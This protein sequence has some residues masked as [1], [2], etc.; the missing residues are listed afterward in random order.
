[1]K[2]LEIRPKFMAYCLGGMPRM[3][4]E[5]A[6]KMM[7]SYFPEAITIPQ[8]TMSQRIWTERVP[9]MKIDRGKKELLFDLSSGRDAE[10]VEFYERY[11]SNDLEYFSISPEI[12][13]LYKL[14]ELWSRE[15]WPEL[16]V[17]HF[18]FPG[19]YSWGLSIK[20]D[21]GTPALYNE[22][23]RDVMIKSMYMKVK[24]REMKARELFPGAETM[25]TLGNGALSVY[26]SA[27]GTG[28]WEDVKRDYIEMVKDASG[29]IG[30]HCC[31]NFD[32]SLLME[33]GVDVL[34]FDAYQYGET[35]C[36]YGEA[37]GRFLEQGGMIAWGIVPTKGVGDIASE[38]PSRLIERLEKIIQRLVDEGT[39]K[40]RLLESSWVTPTC[41]VNTLSIEESKQVYEFTKEISERMREKYFG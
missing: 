10:L 25:V 33:M 4:V 31:S 9:L 17:I 23:L 40:E 39:N 8:P 6:C 18:N 36:L 32:W 14:A 20:D 5:E 29:I 19:L 16:K 27:G 7:I 11:A 41:E 26:F 37:L 28:G 35:I 1:M 2:K 12:D 21:K 38:N 24:W 13:P 34:N 22:T 3:S 30:I 15:P